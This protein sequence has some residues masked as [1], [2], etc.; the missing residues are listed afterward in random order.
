MRRTPTGISDEGTRSNKR[1]T[2]DTNPHQ[3]EDVSTIHGYI[4]NI[5]S[6]CTSIHIHYWAF[7]QLPL[8]KRQCSDNEE[9]DEETYM[10]CIANLNEELEK[11]KPKRKTLKSL[12]S[13]TFAGRRKWITT[14][15]PLVPEIVQTFPL[16]KTPKYVSH[17]MHLVLYNNFY[18]AIHACVYL[19]K[20][21]Q[22]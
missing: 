11:D 15:R 10:E 17:C 12:M 8:P 16:L 1:S 6:T 22:L 19:H 18:L 2:Q 3:S 7:T 9:C 21:T 5:L 14:N 4:H 20:L 13:C